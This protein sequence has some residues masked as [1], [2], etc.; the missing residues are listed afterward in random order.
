MKNLEKNRHGRTSLLVLLTVAAVFLWPTG[1]AAEDGANPTKQRDIVIG[2]F[3]GPTG[4]G[5]APIIV[6]GPVVGTYSSLT[7]EL[8]PEP[9]VMVGRLASG[10]VDI[11]MVPTN[12][13]AQLYNRGI[14]VQIGA[15]TLWGLLYVVGTDDGISDWS[16]LGGRKVQALS[17]GAG[18]D[19]MLRHI[20]SANGVDPQNDLEL[21]YRYGHIELAQMASAG[22]VDLA[23]LPE[24]F[25]TQ[26]LTRRSDMRVVL[27]FQAAW[28]DLHGSAYPQT[29]VLVRR[30]VAEESPDAVREAL[31]AIRAG[32]DE[33]TAYP[34]HG[35][36][37]AAE[38]GMGLPGEVVTAALPRFNARYVS[39]AESKKQLQEYFQI[40]ADAEPRS[41]G[42]AVP[43][44]GIY[45]PFR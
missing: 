43:D 41:V 20:L 37:L 24:P 13:A 4:V 40:L 8:V 36:K 12:M 25:V 15:V 28:E 42:G 32:W 39:V 5:V 27:D 23:V 21:D 16:D 18:P 6:N 34:V 17:R 2:A 31:A 3:R 29:V 10:E 26:V 11:G 22:E 44:D 35:G 9:S 14:P 30:D 19:I 1:L 7:V 33:V 38:A 45:L